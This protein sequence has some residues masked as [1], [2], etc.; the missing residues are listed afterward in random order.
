MSRENQEIL[1]NQALQ[2]MPVVAAKLA[3]PAMVE[4]PEIRGWPLYLPTLVPARQRRGA[5]EVLGRLLIGTIPICFKRAG[6]LTRTTFPNRDLPLSA[7][8]F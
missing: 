6:A 3:F 8:V 2:E 4:I 5:A 1:V 7:K